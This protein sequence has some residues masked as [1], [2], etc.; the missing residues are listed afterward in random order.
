MAFPVQTEWCL[1]WCRDRERH[2]AQFHAGLAQ[3][4]QSALL[5]QHGISIE[6]PSDLTGTQLMS[7]ATAAAAAVASIGKHIQANSNGVN[8]QGE[9]S[10]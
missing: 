8:E 2:T 5:T 3:L 7:V 6:A 4:Q 10:D 9:L 1:L